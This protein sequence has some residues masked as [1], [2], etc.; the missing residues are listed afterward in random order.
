MVTRRQNFQ[1]VYDLSERV[2]PDIVGAPVLT[3]EEARRA[4]LVEAVRA[5]GIARP[6]W[7]VEY[8][9]LIMPKTPLLTV[10]KDLVAEGA[11]CAVAV[12]GSPEPWL[13]PPGPLDIP[14]PGGEPFARLLS[15]VDPINWARARVAELFGFDYQLE[16]YTPAPKRKYGYFSL[17]ILYDGGLVGRLDPKAHR[18]EGIFEVKAL[19]LEDGVAVSDELVTAMKD[20]LA[21]CAQWHGTPDLRVTWANREGLA[22]A[23]SQPL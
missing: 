12:E 23:L 15:P 13:A 1:R 5:L 19:H 4:L 14:A 8:L 6:K 17:P 7:A 2:R 3:I 21:E 16:C 9:F 22:K 20:V 10:L 18:K 11:L